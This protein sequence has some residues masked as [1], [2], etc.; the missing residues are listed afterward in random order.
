M[1][2]DWYTHP[3][4]EGYGEVNTALSDWH[5]MDMI[6]PK[7]LSDLGK[8]VFIALTLALRREGYIRKG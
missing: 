6:G 2:D 5:K 4:V 3:T 8:K 7:R 1:S